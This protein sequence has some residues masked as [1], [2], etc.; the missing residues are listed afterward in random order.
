MPKRNLKDADYE[1]IISSRLIFNKSAPEIAKELDI[2]ET[3]VYNVVSVFQAVQKR[4]IDRVSEQAKTGISGDVI[5]WAYRKLGL[6]IPK[7]VAAA[8]EERKEFNRQRNLEAV[9]RKEAAEKPPENPN[10]G[11]FFCKV[12]EALNKQ[13]E[14]LT[15]LLDVVIPKWTNDLKDNV[16]AN[17]D[18]LQKQLKQMDEKLD[19]IKQNTRR[20]GT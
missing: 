10:D 11:V 5:G 20:R 18:M 15:Q 17:C 12:L 4:D 3:S 14:L 6:E 8:I 9:A 2:G 19:C 16:N 13:N 7:Q 1:A